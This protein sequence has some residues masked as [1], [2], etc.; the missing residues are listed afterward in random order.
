MDTLPQEIVD[1]IVDLL[2]IYSQGQQHPS[3]P[4]ACGKRKHGLTPYAAVSRR[5]QYAVERILFKELSIGQYEDAEIDKLNYILRGSDSGGRRRSGYVRVIKCRY[6]AMMT[7]RF[8]PYMHKLLAFI[9]E[10]W[11]QE[12]KLTLEIRFIF[13]GTEMRMLSYQL[14][15]ERG[16]P[17]QNARPKQPVKTPEENMPVDLPVTL[18]IRNFHPDI[19]GIMGDW[20]SSQLP[21]D[22]LTRTQAAMPM[23]AGMRLPMSRLTTPE[24]RKICQSL[25]ALP[26]WANLQALALDIKSKTTMQVYRI[27]YKLSTRL[28]RLIVRG[29]F[30]IPPEFFW[31]SQADDAPT[32]RTNEC[33]AV[34]NNTVLPFWPHLELLEFRLSG[35][36]NGVPRRLFTWSNMPA[37]YE[38]DASEVEHWEWDEDWEPESEAGCT[39]EQAQV[40]T[41]SQRHPQLDS[42]ALL[43]R[44]ACRDTPGWKPV[45]FDALI[46]AISRAMLRMPKLQAL[47]LSSNSTEM[48]R[49]GFRQPRAVWLSDKQ[50]TFPFYYDHLLPVYPVQT[51]P[52]LY[53]PLIDFQKETDGQWKPTAEVQRNW[54]ELRRRRRRELGLST[55][56]T[57][58]FQGKADKD[59]LERLGISDGF[60]V[61]EEGWKV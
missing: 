21:P 43:Y 23:V 12:S 55:T 57:G 3:R 41:V 38:L 52:R 20:Y 32:G 15:Y 22:W 24:Q 8:Y 10:H 1:A 50:P 27:L 25:T 37:R 35:Y 61:G 29:D 16:D 2:L 19:A 56:D 45:D 34:D 59:F 47:I 51:D 5:F 13:T 17:W 42:M 9:N 6:Y 40:E 60:H 11:S 39:P 53:T 46:L 54:H 30:V 4:S 36:L 26:N 28:R 7:N 14:A 18:A 48:M 44:E 58:K 31:P 49:R 33:E